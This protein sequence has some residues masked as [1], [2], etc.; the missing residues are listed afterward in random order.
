MSERKYPFVVGNDSREYFILQ[1]LDGLRLL[2][3]MGREA[4]E[5]LDG[6]E[7]SGS[8]NRPTFW[9]QANQYNPKEHPKLKRNRFPEYRPVSPDDLPGLADAYLELGRGKRSS[10]GG[11][12]CV[13][14]SL[15]LRAIGI[16][17]V[18]LDTKKKRLVARPVKNLVGFLRVSQKT[19][20]YV[21]NSAQK[22]TTIKKDVEAMVREVEKAD[23]AISALSIRVATNMVS[24][25]SNPWTQ[26]GRDLQTAAKI[27]V[28]SEGHALRMLQ[29]VIRDLQV[30]NVMDE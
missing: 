22:L 20:S 25:D 11:H 13:E 9:A 28:K 6:L 14:Y 16:R 5:A 30:K 19:I 15:C 1:A 27:W 26:K 18:M 10:Y 4:Q 8:W 7:K 2:A 3:Q 21:E 23:G 24:C 29:Q 12:K 17:D